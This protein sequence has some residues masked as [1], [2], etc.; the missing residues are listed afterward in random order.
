MVKCSNCGAE[1]TDSAFCFQCGEKVSS[2]QT[3][4]K[5]CAQNVALLM[6]KTLIFVETVDTK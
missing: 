1:V 4:K 3:D 6:I 5:I 2:P